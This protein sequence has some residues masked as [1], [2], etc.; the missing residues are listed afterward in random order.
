MHIILAIQMTS[1][2]FKNENI[3]SKSGLV[4]EIRTTD[5]AVRKVRLMLKEMSKE[6]QISA[7]VYLR[8]FKTF[9]V[10]FSRFFV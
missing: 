2:G 6:A 8:F 5:H 10:L 1:L 3:L 7:C 9:S 4:S